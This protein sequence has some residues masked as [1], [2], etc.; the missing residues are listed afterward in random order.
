MVPPPFV[1]S[2]IR[3]DVEGWSTQTRQ[4]FCVKVCPFCLQLIRKS[5]DFFPMIGR[6]PFPPTDA[7]FSCLLRGWVFRFVRGTFPSLWTLHVPITDA[8]AKTLFNRFF[9]FFFFGWFWFFFFVLFLW[10]GWGFLFLGF[11]LASL[12]S[13]HPSFWKFVSWFLSKRSLLVLYLTCF[14]AFFFFQFSTAFS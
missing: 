2:F 12:G 3:V 14:Q 7:R 8:L 4:L 11:F 13:E 5:L 6:D 1:S 9:V 10:G